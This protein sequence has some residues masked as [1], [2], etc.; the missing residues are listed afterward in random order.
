MDPQNQT[1]PTMTPK[2]PAPTEPGGGDDAEPGPGTP[3]HPSVAPTS[4]PQRTALPSDTPLSPTTA[5]PSAVIGAATPAA[6]WDFGDAPDPGFPSLLAS[7]GARHFIV[8]F[9]WL[10]EGVNQE[11]DSQQVDADLYDDGVQPGELLTCQEADVQVTVS[12]ASRGTTR[13]TPTTGS[14]CCT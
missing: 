9:E 3:T 13:S 4:S 8:Q 11:L 7:E 10:G 12:V 5:S 2:R 6:G 1:V 14:T